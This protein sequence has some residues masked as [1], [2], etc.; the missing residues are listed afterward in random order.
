MAKVWK[1][2]QILRSLDHVGMF[3]PENISLI[4]RHFQPDINKIH[5]V[6]VN[7]P[8]MFFCPYPRDTLTT[9]FS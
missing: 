4:L 3:L 2:V 7:G 1:E 8:N 5:N 9:L 6:N